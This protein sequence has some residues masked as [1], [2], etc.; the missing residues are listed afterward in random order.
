MRRGALVA[1]SSAVLYGLTTPFTALL[2]LRLGTFA[3]AAA[4]YLGAGVLALVRRGTI[5][6]GEWPWL[7]ASALTG[8]VAAPALLVAGLRHTDPATA[9]L[10]LAT[11]A[12]ATALIAWFVVREHASRRTVAGMIAIAAGGAILAWHGSP[13]G[14]AGAL[15]VLGAALAW[16]IDDNLA[17]RLAA[18]DALTIAGVKGLIGGCVS[19]VVVAAGGGLAQ[20]DVRAFAAALLV[21]L[22]GYGVSVALFVAAQR[23]LGTAR[24]AA[25]FGAAPLIGAAAAVA[26]GARPDGPAFAVAAVLTT[27]GIALHAT[28][29]HVHGHRHEPLVHEHDHE[30]D[31][32]HRHA[33]PHALAPATPHRHVHRHD[34]LAHA[35]P[36][37]PDLHHR[38]DHHHA[39]GAPHRVAR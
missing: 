8:G 37:A 28:E 39:P 19:L 21:G 3:L 6:R 2:A 17:R 25:Y 12:V 27:A 31:E 5:A 18:S 35:H 29:R 36:H 16:A 11:Q 33:H 32:H 13:T 30:H 20:L 10:L 7:L 34:E 4:L 9:S 23:D 24:T 22:I 1:F 15:L 26:F 14:S 38:H